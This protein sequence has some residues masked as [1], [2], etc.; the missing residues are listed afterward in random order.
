MLNLKVR[1]VVQAV[2]ARSAKVNS[3]LSRDCSPNAHEDAIYLG[4]AIAILPLV[5]Q[6]ISILHLLH[7]SPVP[8]ANWDP[9]LAVWDMCLNPI[10]PAT[11]VSWERHRV[12]V[13]AGL[14][15]RR[16]RPRSHRR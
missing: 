7:Q 16:A 6:T 14:C 11:L 4:R 13:A 5:D 10:A 3:S 2:Q 12:E 9:S 1:V 8:I 15:R